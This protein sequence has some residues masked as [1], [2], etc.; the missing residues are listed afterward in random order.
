MWWMVSAAFAQAAP[1][2]VIHTEA[3]PT[4]AP[5]PMRNGPSVG[6]S[7][8]LATGFGPTLGVPLG[9]WF[10]VQ[11]TALPIVV[12]DAG[13]GGSV[14]LR[15]QQFLGRNPRARMYLVEGASWTGW[16]GSGIWGA[17]VGAGV[18]TRKDWSTGRSLWLDV[19]LTAMGGDGGLI[20]VLPLPQTG[21]AWTF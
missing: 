19:T 14:G 12:P 9:P 17:G 4:V 3:A 20:A 2:V 5:E 21:V 11:L 13:A 10:A 7:A 1:Q 16:D 6:L 15:T 18:D 8:G